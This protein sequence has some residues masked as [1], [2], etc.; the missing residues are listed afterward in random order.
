MKKEKLKWLFL[1]LLIIFIVGFI[2]IKTIKKEEVSSS[3]TSIIDTTLNTDDGDEDVDW[4]KYDTTEVALTDSVSITKEGIYVLSGTIENGNIK[5]NVDGNVKLILNNV[6]ITNTNGPAIYIEQADTTMI[7]LKTGSTN[8][9]S[10]GESYSDEY[11]DMD[12]TIFSKDDLVL[13]GEGSLTINANYLDGLVSKD[14]L[15]IS[16]GTYKIISNDDAIRGK[17]SVYIQ[18]GEFTIESRGDGIKTTNDTDEDKGFILIENGTF[19]IDAS[20]DGIQAEKKLVIQNGT[21]TITTGDSS[22]NTSTLD[23]WGMWG[24]RSITTDTESAKGLKAVD[25]IVIENGTF[26]FDT[27][28]DAIH[29]NNYVGIKHGNITISSGDDGIHADKEIIIDNGTITIEKS[30]EGI[31]ASKITINNGNIS[32]KASDDGINVAGGNDSSSMNRPGQNN[33]SSSDNKLI[34]NSGSIY[35]NASGDGID[36]NGSG[37]IYGGNIIVDGPSDNGNASLD[38]D[39]EISITEGTLLAV[40]SSGMAQGLSS[41]SSQYSVMINLSKNYSSNQ[42]IEIIDENNNVIVSHTT[43]K[44]FSSIVYSTSLFEKGSN[45]TLKIDGNE[46]TTFT[47]SS[48]TNK[49]GNSNQGMGRR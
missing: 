43:I 25:N 13:D 6:N 36:I 17:D 19:T 8:Y 41:S 27:S 30:Y 28:D 1:I 5:V 22:A 32:I 15:K 11:T 44:S 10:D 39:G 34:I 31:E 42:K 46:V 23:T 18:N 9:L 33:F 14:D 20:L 4:T 47:I 3:D 37:Y 16:N 29:S 2:Y 49:V 48:I 40:G 38:Y 24:N 35:V 21:F 26:N 45:Y 12:G 7:Y